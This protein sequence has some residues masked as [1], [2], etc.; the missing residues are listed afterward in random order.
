MSQKLN[1]LVAV[2][3]PSMA[4]YRENLRKEPQFAVTI[5][6]DLDKVR[7]AMDDASKHTDVLVLDNGLGDEIHRLI[8]EVRQSFPRLLII[9]VDESADFAMPGRADDVTTTPFENDDLITRIKRLHED[10]HLQTLRAD[11][12]PPVRVFAKSLLKA[13]K[14]K[15]KQQAAVEAIKEIGYDY[16]AFYS[17]TAT[18]PPEMTLVAQVGPPDAVSSAPKKQDYEGSLVG[19]V[20]RSGQSRIL[21]AGEEAVHPFLQKKRYAVAVCVPV[22]TTLRF[23]VLLACKEAEKSITQENVMILELISAQLASA[24]AKD[25]RG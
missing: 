19:G 16:V 9:L 22:G 2:Q 10:R 25:A 20:A 5:V 6:T 4:K 12:L 21:N 23:G 3:L 14:G 13:G 17:L 18:N 11:A 1:V 15:A 24:L 7:E 8:K